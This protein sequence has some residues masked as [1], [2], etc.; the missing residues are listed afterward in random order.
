MFIFVRN[1]SNPEN[2]NCIATTRSQTRANDSYHKQ[3][4]M[5]RPNNN[6][7][8]KEPVPDVP[9]LRSVLI[10]APSSFESVPAPRSLL[11]AKPPPSAAVIATQSHKEKNTTGQP[12]WTLTKSQLVPL[13][14]V[15]PLERSHVYIDAVNVQEVATNIAECLRKESIS[16]C[17][18]STKVRIKL[19]VTETS[20]V[21]LFTYISLSLGHGTCGNTTT[22]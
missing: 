3:T 8:K 22:C 19:N 21:Q 16:S 1:Q 9:H 5:S 13:P 4:N 20:G 12:C 10:R 15:Y 7:A 2:F 18:D 6:R 17:F 14:E 11:S